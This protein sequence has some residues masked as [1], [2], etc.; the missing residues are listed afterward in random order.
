MQQSSRIVV[1]AAMAVARRVRR[2]A[3]R[4]GRARHRGRLRAPRDVAAQSRS[5]R[6]DGGRTGQPCA[7][8]AHVRRAAGRRRGGAR[9]GR[10]Q[11]DRPAAAPRR[12][13]TTR[14]A[15]STS[16][17]S[18]AT[19][20]SSQALEQKYPPPNQLLRRLQ[21]K[22]DRSKLTPA[23]RDGT[24][25]RHG[26]R[27]EGHGGGAERAHR[28][29]AAHRA[30]AAGSHDR[31][32]AQPLLRLH[33]EGA[34]GALPARAVRE[35]GD[36]PELA[37]KIPHAAR[38]GGEEPGDAVLSRQLGEP[39]GQQPSAARAD[40]RGAAG[41]AQERPWRTAHARSSSRRPRAGAADSTRTTVASCSSC[42]RSASMAATP[43][44]TSSTS[45]AR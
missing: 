35:Q 4:A 37:R 41:L 42:T 33:P 18:R 39:G 38:G 30:A 22:G 9:H 12:A 36:P 16:P 45:R 20:R 43:S 44:R 1:A 32:L 2:H 24:R 26:R 10:R 7:E 15:T 5:A 13:S 27:A 25:R 29:R 34:A 17:R 21:A 31:L 8:P 40:P 11:V 19:T 3:G 6:T 14:R 28:P 23:E